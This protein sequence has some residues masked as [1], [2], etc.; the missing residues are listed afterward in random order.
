MKS[1]QN[2]AA[3]SG[4]APATESEECALLQTQ[5][6]ATKRSPWRVLA[7]ALIVVSTVCFIVCVYILG[8]SDKYATER[9]F[10]QYWAVGKQLIHG[11]N[12]YDISA[13]GR[14]ERTV[15]LDGSPPRV[16]LSPPTAFVLVLPLGLVS[17]KTG[18][19][20]WSVVLLACLSVSTW[21]LWILNGRPDNRFHLFG[22][23][24]APVLAC[25]IS[26]QLSIFLL[27]GIVLF[28]YFHESR[29]GL[30]GAALLPCA[31]KPHLFLLFAIVL[32][33]WVVRQRAF[34]ILV[35]FFA[36]LLAS[37]A[38]TLYFDIHVWSQYLQMM[39]ETS[40]LQVFIPTFGGALRFLIDRHVVGL[41]F[42]P[43]AAGCGWAL[44]YFWTRRNR[45][46]WMDQGLLLLL[47]SAA[48]AP[49]GFFTDECILLPYV[50]AG[51]Y[52]AVDLRRSFLLLVL[53]NGV[54]AVEIFAQVNIISPFYL[55][56]VPAW[57]AWY[58]YATWSKGNQAEGIRSN[59][60]GVAD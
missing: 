46:S 48:C 32:V 43:A 11:A 21:I 18:L 14:L 24:F 23:V 45:W 6:S 47:V 16:T 44:W 50:L 38:L 1:K 42:L 37:C 12:P 10:I 4:P 34:R 29:P 9:D 26:G 20:V 60:E 27:L 52:Q 15:G 59:A 35:G 5:S 33:L 55:W 30:A 31:L 3:V 40:I 25:Q 57:L 8:L 19:V 17:P 56:T 53:I 39:S 7:A 13:I 58:L 36:T 22:Y 54:A 28:L 49:Y 51:L 41:Q 2:E